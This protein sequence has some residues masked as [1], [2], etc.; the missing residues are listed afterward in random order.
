MANLNLNTQCQQ[1]RHQAMCLSSPLTRISDLEVER[2]LL[3][4]LKFSCIVLETR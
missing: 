1:H 3:D 2:D 4:G